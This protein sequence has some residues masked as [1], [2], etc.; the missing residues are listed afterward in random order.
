MPIFSHNQL[1]DMLNHLR[2]KVADLQAEEER[3][4]EKTFELERLEAGIKSLQENF[5]WLFGFGRAPVQAVEAEFKLTES[6]KGPG[7]PKKEQD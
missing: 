4:E 7:R 3:K 1:N 6:K 2:K 5:E